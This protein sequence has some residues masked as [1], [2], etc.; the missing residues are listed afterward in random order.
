[1]KVIVEADG[2][3]RGNPGPAGYGAVVR[4]P[5]GAVLAER[6]GAL[7]H[8]TNNV[9]EYTG[10]IEGLR[11]ALELGATDV[12]AR[13]DSKLVVEQMSGR[14]RIRQ[15]HLQP[16]AGDAAALVRR[17]GSVRFQWVPRERNRHADR[18]ANE[19]MDRARDA[20]AEGEQRPSRRPAPAE[21]PAPPLAWRG[22]SEPPTRLVLLRHGQT[23]HSIRRAYSGRGD[24][25]LTSTGET[26][27]ALAAKR[28]AGLTALTEVV[29][30]VSSPLRR[31]VQTAEP[32]AAQLGLPV[33]VHDGLIEADYGDWEG[34][35]FAEVAARNPDLHARWLHDTSVAP[36]G[37]ESL[38][39]VRRRVRR[40]R[41]ALIV[42]HPGATVVVVSHVAPVKTLLAIA[43]DAWPS[44]LFRLHLD[45][46]SVSVAEFFPDG[47]AVRLVNDTS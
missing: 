16:L 25:P 40:A 47:A 15:P 19:A 39:S 29:A 12:E 20:Q 10:L 31:A 5:A 9:A 13:L 38:D 26:Q 30:V 41:D 8:T 18:L 2:G 4:D 22:E 3:S 27:A 28:L 46:A 34:M 21:P 24:L 23:E 43:L 36:P 35:T 44:V 32:V 17:L 7:G 45:L 37:G 42:D 1:M 14:W 6:S 33:T 11:A